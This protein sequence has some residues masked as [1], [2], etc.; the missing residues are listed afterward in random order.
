M[1]TARITGTVTCL[2]LADGPVAVTAYPERGRDQAPGARA[3]LNDG[4]GVFHLLVPPGVWWLEATVDQ[5]SIPGAGAVSAW[6]HDP[7]T[8]EAGDQV[9]GVEIVVE[10]PE[11]VR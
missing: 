8:V 4:P 1:E 9:E 10:V 3:E 7:V 6:C 11:Q 2:E 5:G